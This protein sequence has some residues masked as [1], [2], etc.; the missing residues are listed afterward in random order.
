MP[1]KVVFDCCV[2]SN[3]ALAG[4][5]RVVEDLYPRRA[6]ITSFVSAEVLHGIQAGHAELEAI[7]S[8]VR[9]GRLGIADIESNEE[10]AL[11]ESLSVS[12]G[13]GEASSLAVA[14]FR[15]RRFATDDAAARS[16]ARK[17]GIDLTGTIGILR[18]AVELRISD[19]RT[20]RAYLAK[21]VKRGF[22]SPI[23]TL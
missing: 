14:R 7:V 21:M 18:K 17:L 22:Y 20:A 5:L 11:F 9:A 10:R 16:E 23:N 3:F 13:L 15:R 1:E 19:S 8:A 12:L 6:A 4:A 2:I